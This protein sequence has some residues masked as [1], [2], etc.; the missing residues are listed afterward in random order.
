MNR[1][2]A[3]AVARAG[4]ARLA[5]QLLGVHVG[6]R[7]SA[8]PSCPAG[9][10]AAQGGHAADP[11]VPAC[12]MAYVLRVHRGDPAPWGMQTLA[13]VAKL[14]AVKQQL[15]GLE[16]AAPAAIGAS[17]LAGAP[18]PHLAVCTTLA[19]H[20]MPSIL[21][22]GTLDVLSSGATRRFW[23]L[24]EAGGPGASAYCTGGPLPSVLGSGFR[25][26]ET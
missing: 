17:V 12:D 5:S 24:L 18:R 22:S 16:L 19:E 3:C 20:A 13:K 9:S 25:D 1:R 26:L 2:W 23:A 4:Q 21:R 7:V 6:R 10:S 15:W 8:A 11:S 14:D